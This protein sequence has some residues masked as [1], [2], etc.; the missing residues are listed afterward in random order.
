MKMFMILNL[1]L[2]WAVC[3]FSAE[4]T[5]MQVCQ[6]LVE[7]AKTDNYA[8]L[9]DAMTEME[10]HHMGKDTKTKESFHK[11]HG[12][13]LDKIKTLTCGTEH[14]ADTHAFVEA[15]AQ[16][17]KRLVPFVKVGGLWKFDT[18]TYKT[19]YST[20]KHHGEKTETK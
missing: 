6:K 8:S 4:T 1:A 5:P 12:D 20:G 17:E 14:V 3:G 18:K 15:E 13:Y 16:G 2:L 7:A 11:M 10:A 19:F 9:K